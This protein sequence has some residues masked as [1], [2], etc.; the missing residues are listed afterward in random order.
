MLHLSRYCQEG[1]QELDRDHKKYWESL[2]GLKHAK[3]FLQGT[4]AGRTTELLKQKPVRWGTGL[5]TGHCHQKGHLL[6]LEPANNPIS[7]HYIG[8][9]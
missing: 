8:M 2:T 4:S 1:Y 5:L 3:G 9:L 7:E 6:E